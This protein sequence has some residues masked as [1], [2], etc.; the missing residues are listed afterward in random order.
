MDQP[1]TRA[2]AKVRLQRE[3]RW[4]EALAFREGL[5]KEGVLPAEA[6][7][8]MLEKFPPLAANQQ[9]P[10]EPDSSPI[11][12]EAPS[13]AKT[14]RRRCKP[15][16]SPADIRGDIGWAY[17]NIGIDPDN[18]IPPSAGALE[19]LKLARKS[20][21]EFLKV[22]AS[23][24][25]LSKAE[26]DAEEKRRRQE[27]RDAMRDSFHRER[28]EQVTRELVH[29]WTLDECRKRVAEADAPKNSTTTSLPRPPPA[30]VPEP[31]V[32]PDP[33]QPIDPPAPPKLRLCPHGN[34]LG[35]GDQC[36][37]CEYHRHYAEIESARAGDK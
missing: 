21:A 29:T 33:P 6:H 17:Q 5:K 23:K 10:D 15:K 37:A 1:E 26:Q 35:P 20:P 27:E 32:E 11:S 36:L 30:S 16:Q 22:F 25:I 31:V 18:L 9:Q 28:E 14:R 2:E 13:P 19:L 34:R 7:R 12:Q 8:L 4:Q 24:L 3:K